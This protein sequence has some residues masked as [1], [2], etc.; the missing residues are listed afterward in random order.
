VA[1]VSGRWLETWALEIVRYTIGANNWQSRESRR[2]QAVGI[3]LHKRKNSV[4]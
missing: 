1:R 2:F 3:R 4:G